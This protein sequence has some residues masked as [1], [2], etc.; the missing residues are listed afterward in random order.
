MLLFLILIQPAYETR[1]VQEKSTH[2]HF[3]AQKRHH[4]HQIN[5]IMIEITVEIES[6]SSEGSIC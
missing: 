6:N 1:N 3:F 5:I 4:N 2:L